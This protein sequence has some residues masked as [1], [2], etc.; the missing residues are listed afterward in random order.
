VEVP[1]SYD[2][3][4][5]LSK[6]SSLRTLSLRAPSLRAVHVAPDDEASMAVPWLSFLSGTT[7]LTELHLTVPT[8]RGLT[9]V[10][11]C[12]DL[13]A[14]Y[15][16]GADDD[17]PALGELEWQA[18]GQLTKLTTLGLTNQLQGCTST[19][20]YHA[21]A[22][23]SKL[24]QVAASQWAADVLPVFEQLP[25]LTSIGGAWQQRAAGSNRV[26]A[27]CCQVGEMFDVSGD[28]PFE[29]FPGVTTVGHVGSLTLGSLS[30]LTQRLKGLQALWAGPERTGQAALD[31]TVQRAGRLQDRIAAVKSLSALTNLCVLGFVPYDNEELTALIGATLPLLSLQLRRLGVVIEQGS[32]ITSMALMHLGRLQGLEQ[33][34]VI[35]LTETVLADPSE[36]STFLFAVAG[37]RRVELQVLTTPRRSALLGVVESNRL[38]DLP[39]PAAVEVFKLDT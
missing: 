39:M 18:I 12:G 6:L 19:A 10:S 1:F 32:T 26:S 13:Q 22:R 21:L 9:A 25:Q 33:L 16:L 17:A 31:A 28:V 23:L 15:L 36:A 4:A 5:A 8:V 3:L 38:L 7:A 20:C 27:S 30:A 35:L 24:E 2:S 14:L 11:S 29:A 34:D 37:V